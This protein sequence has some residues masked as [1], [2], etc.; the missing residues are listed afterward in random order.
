MGRIQTKESLITFELSGEWFALPLNIVEGVARL[1]E[2][3]AVPGNVS[4]VLCGIAY[5]LGQI[6]GVIDC[7]PILNKKPLGQVKDVLVI[8]I[9]EHYY[10]LKVS[11]VGSIVTR[12]AL[13]STKKS[14]V[15]FMKSS[16]IQEKRTV[17]VLNVETLS[18]QLC[19]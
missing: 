4:R 11:Q 17:T 19:N 10:A 13:I 3:I 1:P 16:F 8:R 6:M 18:E 5:I 7:L 9:N 2:V 12:P 14:T 15:Q